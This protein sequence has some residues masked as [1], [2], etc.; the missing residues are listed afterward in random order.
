MT[1]KKNNLQEGLE[2]VNRIKLLMGYDMS[3]T[4]NENLNEQSSV[5]GAPVY[6]SPSGYKPSYPENTKW[7]KESKL[8]YQKEHPEMVW[9]P[10]A[11]DETQPSL[12]QY[13]KTTYPK[14]KFVPITSENVGL[15]G[16][17]FGFHPTEYP[18]YLKK[19]KEVYK[20]YPK[21]ETSILNPTTWFDSDKDEKRE[22]LLQQLKNQYYHKDFPQGITQDQ[23]VKVMSTKKDITKQMK[24][25][26]DSIEKS[27]KNRIPSIGMYPDKKTLDLYNKLNTEK[28]KSKM[29]VAKKYGTMQTYLDAITGYDPVS[30]IE[31]SKSGLEKWWDKYGWAAELVGWVI[32][33][34]F[35]A[36]FA[37]EV[38]A[39]RQVYLLSKVFSKL[40]G[41]K[42]LA[43]IIRFSGSIGLNVA[44]GSYITIKNQKLTEDAVL[45]FVFAFLPEVH[46]LFKIKGAPS[47][48]TCENIISKMSK[49]NLHDPS[50]LR[51]FMNILTTEEKQLFREVAL[52]DKTTL[53]NGLEGTMKLVANKGEKKLI[54]AISNVKDRKVNVG[55]NKLLK[56]GKFVGTL[57]V[58]LS[59]IEIVT[60]I[61]RK[62][63]LLDKYDKEK[64]FIKRFHEELSKRQ[65][66]KYQMILMV[67]TF[68]TLK[69]HPD[70]NPDLIMSSSVKE[71]NSD[72]LQ[73]NYEKTLKGL[74]QYDIE[75]LILDTDGKPYKF[76]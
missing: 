13:G 53:K 64:E 7:T 33:D 63:G 42:Q 32:A 30:I 36:G 51:L 74:S 61:T 15:R 58:D 57:A 76:N 16:T 8:K 18:E 4:L 46:N 11:F 52:I 24:K 43:K 67:N 26:L 12:N 50:Q 28:G 23:F 2:S 59:L 41:A 29:E 62:T 44:I 71:T 25:E 14:G 49:Y 47:V 40:G 1:P 45:Y 9:D 27:Y 6:V 10:E 3:K 34:Y 39:G 19:V 55:L 37:A 73:N 75:S 66:P 35:T 72:I 70:W 21:S 20:K 65:D 69:E 54:N 17:P 48:A 56:L 68:D 38:A 22:K 5:I 31:I 60:E